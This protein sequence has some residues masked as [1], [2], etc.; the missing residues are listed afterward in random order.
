MPKINIVSL[1][2]EITFSDPADT[3]FDIFQQHQVDWMH[4]CGLKG[5]CTTCCM[6]VLE[7][8]GNI[9][10]LSK[11]ESNYAKMGCLRKNERLACQ[12]TLSGNIRI[13]VPFNC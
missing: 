3:I 7:G 9:S 6:I 10:G 13:A 12:C 8:I 5:R 2:K 11:R 1:G 4:S